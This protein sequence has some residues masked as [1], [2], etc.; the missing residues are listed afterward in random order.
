MDG[1]AR[2]L[3]VFTIPVSAGF[4]C[5]EEIFNRLTKRHPEVEWYFGNVYDPVDGSHCSVGGRMREAAA[6]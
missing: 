3:T 6:S 1:R 5:V 2:G 4:A